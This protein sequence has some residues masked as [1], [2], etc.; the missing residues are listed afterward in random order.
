MTIL[1]II[2]FFVDISFAANNTNAKNERTTKLEEQVSKGYSSKFCNAIGMGVSPQ[3][4]MKLSI[5]ENSKPSFN[6]SL[7]YE[8]V[9]SGEE[10]IRE[11]NPIAAK[12]SLGADI[13]VLVI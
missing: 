8:L 12:K 10:N 4:A 1:L 9:V 7:W 3:G 11:L 6:P 5:N 13:V 2:S